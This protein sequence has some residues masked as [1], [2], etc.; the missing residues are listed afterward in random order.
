MNLI[1]SGKK[2]HLPLEHNIHRPPPVICLE[3]DVGD[4]LGQS[5]LADNVHL[6]FAVTVDVDM[7]RLVI[8]GLYREAQPVLAM[9]RDHECR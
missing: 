8:F 9:N 4:L 2:F 5:A 6:Q 1:P 7:R 3:P